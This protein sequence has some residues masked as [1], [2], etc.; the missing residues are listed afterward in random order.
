MPHFHI[1][2][3]ANLEDADIGGLC[4]AVRAAAVQVEAFPMPGVRVRATRVDHYAIA[5]GDPK[6]GFVDISI[7]LRGGRPDEVK[8]AA[9]QAIFEAARVFLA[10]VM[11]ERSIALSLE[12]RDIDPALSPKAGTVREHLS[13]G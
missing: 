12:M 11:A 5:D 7:R 6:H 2:Y 10:P 13:Q 3:S 9:T 8:A 4:E 1:E